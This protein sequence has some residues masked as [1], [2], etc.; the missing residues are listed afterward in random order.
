MFGQD[1][2]E[3]KVRLIFQLHAGVGGE[4]LQKLEGALAIYFRENC[5]TSNGS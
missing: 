5:S 3:P 4:N 1:F 2:Y